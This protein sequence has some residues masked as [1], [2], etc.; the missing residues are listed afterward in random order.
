MKKRILSV[1]IAV[2]IFVLPLTVVSFAGEDDA[3]NI[4]NNAF[5][6]ELPEDFELTFIY[7]DE[8]DEE[9]GV[10]YTY[11]IAS[12]DV[13]V[14]DYSYISVLENKMGVDNVEEDVAELDKFF[15]S[16]ISAYVYVESPDDI[17]TKAVSEVNGYKCIEYTGAEVYDKGTMYETSY[18]YKAY[19][20]ATAENIYC[21]VVETDNASSKIAESLMKS[22]TLNGTLLAGDSHKN[23]VD[24]STAE[25]YKEQ[26]A[27]FEYNYQ[28]FDA[29]TNSAARMGMV[30][31]LIPFIALL[32][33][34]IV[35]IAKY[36]KNKKILEQY[37]KTFG[38]MGFP[39]MPNGYMM[40]N[41]MNYGAPNGYQ[42]TPQQPVQPMQSTQPINQD[43]Q[44]QNGNNGQNNIF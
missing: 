2:C 40:N 13:D 8:Y 18:Y 31:L 15:S 27:N 25:D 39:S 34:T 7:E 5:Y 12:T 36:S 41:Q 11:E 4:L 22:F 33:A 32:V 6:V 28:S 43:Y 38:V 44:N 20:F 3:N 26:A 16:I 35:V 30:I 9:Y 1:I 42:T 10:G 24:F 37:E 19:A 14:Y 29:E 17:F 21:V 23:K